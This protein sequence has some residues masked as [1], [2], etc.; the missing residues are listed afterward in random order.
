MSIIT[1]DGPMSSALSTEEYV[2]LINDLTKWTNR[3]QRVVT[4]GNVTVIGAGKVTWRMRTWRAVYWMR[5]I[6]MRL[7]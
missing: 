6:I 3:T 1:R 5:G 7:V 4:S 2:R